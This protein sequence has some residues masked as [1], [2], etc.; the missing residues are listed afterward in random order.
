MERKRLVR[1]T[2]LMILPALVSCNDIIREK[3]DIEV[4]IAFIDTDFSSKAL[5]PDE[6]RVNNAGIFIFDSNGMLEKS[7]WQDG[8][9]SSEGVKV[10]LLSGKEYRFI[11]YVNFGYRIH[12]G[13]L[14]DLMDHRFHLAYPD[15]Y[16][17]GMP[18]TGDSG[19]I[20]V[21]D[22][23]QISLELTRLM[24]KISLRIDR[25]RL[26]DHV[27]MLIRSVKIGNCPKSALAFGTNKVDSH[28]E[29]FTTGFYRNAEECSPL[30]EMGERGVSKTVSV[31]MLENMQGRW[32][33]TD[34][35]EDSDKVF[36]R[37]DSRQEVCSYIE[38]GIDYLSPEWKSQ[39]NGLIYRFYL[40]EN[41]NNLDIERNCHYR[42]TVCPEQ[43]GLSEDSWR[44][45]KSNLSYNGDISFRSWPESY[46][47]GDI[48]DKI[49]IGCS[50]T[51]S[52]APFDIGIEELMEDKQN[53]IYDFEIDTDGHGVTLTLTGPG[54]G[55]VYMEAGDPVNESAMWVIEVN[56]QQ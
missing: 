16:R 38:L 25:R 18:M 4:N 40:G 46:V 41:R 47:R 36:D 50:F 52:F 28:D 10:N 20:R 17:E 19:L 13:N 11:A 2:L 3:N 24:A 49:H 34:I 39:G 26:S 6:N 29:C 30:N 9:N 27:E 21:K 53:G 15:E 12:T 56:Q 14:D 31:Y 48:G 35:G 43:D 54:R 44:V 8:W 23:E 7:I 22:G 51:P 45:D 1:H 37:N 42:V 5:D 32:A 33:D 55:L